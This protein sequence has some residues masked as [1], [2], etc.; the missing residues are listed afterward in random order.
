[1]T[2]LIISTLAI[3]SLFVTVSTANAGWICVEFCCEWVP[4]CV[5]NCL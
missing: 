3:G 5:N 2:K 4:Y 1:M